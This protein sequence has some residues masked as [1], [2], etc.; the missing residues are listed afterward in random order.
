ME[1]TES[2]FSSARLSMRLLCADDAA[3]YTR[4]YCDPQLMQFVGAAMASPA[5]ARSFAASAAA[6]QSKNWRLRYWVMTEKQSSAQIGLLGLVRNR[7]V[8]S[9]DAAELGTMILQDW[10]RRGFAIEG[11]SALMTF[12]FR[13]EGLERLQGMQMPGHTASIQLMTRLGFERAADVPTNVHG[14]RWTL[15]RS[16]WEGHSSHPVAM[17]AC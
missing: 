9:V 7:A 14:L 4:I 2:S 6:S 10:Q 8:P 15:D 5:A 1:S 13:V 16:A 12:A 17:D 11:L 3:L